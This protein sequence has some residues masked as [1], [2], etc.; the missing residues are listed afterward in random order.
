MTIRTEDCLGPVGDAFH[1]RV[2]GHQGQRGGAQEDAA[3]RKG[4][5]GG[6]SDL[7]SSLFGQDGG[8]NGGERG[9]GD[10]AKGSPRSPGEG[11]G[12]GI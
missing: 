8:N 11:G 10:G 9:V 6:S 1:E 2:S 4:R 3:I 5:R 7:V 12:G